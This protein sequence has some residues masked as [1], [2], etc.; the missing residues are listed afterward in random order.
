MKNIYLFGIL[1]ILF[2]T[3][4]SSTYKVTNFP[5]KDKFYEDFNETFKEREA[6]VTLVNDSSFY[7]DKGVVVKNSL[8]VCYSTV[9]DKR[10]QKFI[11]SDLS[12]VTFG[13]KENKSA[14]I[15]LKSGVEFSGENVSTVRD[16]I[17]FTEVRRLL[18][19]DSFPID[20]VRTASYVSNWKGVFPGMKLGFA[21][22]SLLGYFVG[23]NITQQKGGNSTPNERES[24]EFTGFFLGGTLGL[25]TG[26]IVGYIVG[27]DISYQFTP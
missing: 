19:I 9:E 1:F 4:C 3:G 11:L 10:P 24:Q 21:T 15:I 8:V 14:K 16:S 12:S 6:K 20:K 7:V 22:A 23:K 5:S 25:L 17:N 2:F 27:Y 18:K 26:A 13:G